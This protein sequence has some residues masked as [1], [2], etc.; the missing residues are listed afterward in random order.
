MR[1]LCPH[2]ALP[3]R[4][5]PSRRLW[6]ASVRAGLPSAALS[7]L[8]ARLGPSCVLAPSLRLRRGGSRTALRASLRERRGGVP[9]PS[10][11]L[12]SLCALRSRFRL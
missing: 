9:L 8:P 5:V 12:A 6:L 4:R 10:S 3:P 11:L 7:A 2:P 1:C